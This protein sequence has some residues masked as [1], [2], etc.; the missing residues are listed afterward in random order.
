MPTAAARVP[1]VP[2]NPHS[3]AIV[4]ASTNPD[5]YSYQAVVAYLAKGWTVWPVHPS[6]QPIAGLTTYADISKLPGR[7]DIICMYLNPT[8][9]LAMLEAIIAT[10][11]T[12]LWLN[13]G[14]DG[15]PLASVARA[16]GLHVVE[17]CNLVALRLGDPLEIGLRKK[18]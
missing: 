5:R 14:A 11:P 3:V 6:A 7:P 1:S 15:E 17:A 2:L 13:P 8:A 16:R 12:L 9:G 10:Q 18:A 4:G